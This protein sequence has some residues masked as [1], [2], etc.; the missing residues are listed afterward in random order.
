MYHSVLHLL[1]GTEPVEVQLELELP[2]ALQKQLLDQ[3][4]AMHDEGRTVALPRQPNV[5]QILQGYVQY[6]RDKQ[7]E[8]QAEEDIVMGLQ[9]G[10]YSGGRVV[11][12][13]LQGASAECKFR[14]W[15]WDA[16][17]AVGR[18]GRVAHILQGCVQCC[19]TRV[20]VV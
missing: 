4:D 19:N 11:A 18:W 9:V 5:A 8:S 20:A 12:R 10:V 16:M 13:L 3:Y 14:I 17:S 15:G 7:G 2:A 1:A 6:V